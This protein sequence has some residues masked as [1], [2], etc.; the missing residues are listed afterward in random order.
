MN[1]R[2]TVL[3]L[4]V[5]LSISCFAQAGIQSA[6]TSNTAQPNG[7]DLKD[8]KIDQL[9]GAQVPLTTPFNDWNGSPVNF[10]TLLG[11]R[12]AI[13]VPIFYNCTGVCQLELASLCDAIPKMKSLKLGK[14][15]DVVILSI[16][17]TETP[18]LAS[19]KR[20]TLINT[21]KMPGT[22]N[23]WHCLTGALP[24]IRSVTNAV[25]FHYTYDVQLNIVN[26]PSGIMVVAPSGQVS[27]YLYGADYSP[28]TL[29]RDIQVASKNQVGEK[30]TE[31]FFGC[32]HCD[33][34]TGKKT[35]VF[36]NVLRLFG[37]VTIMAILGTLLSLSGKKL[38]HKGD[39]ISQQ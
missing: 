35:I 13:L 9:L 15:Y 18:A 39:P 3:G 23:G 1:L 27:S 19:T 29:A 10:G 6:V 24:N 22:E 16:N 17:P 38:F 36:Q 20:N 7:P 25:G 33:P 26:H 14:D 2:A 31:I 5:T 4:F 32:I 30:T 34:I 12:P 11:Q 28:T 37:V 8:I 21:V